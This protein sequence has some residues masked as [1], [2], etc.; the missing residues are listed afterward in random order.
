MLF[1]VDKPMAEIAFRTANTEPD[2]EIVLIQD[3]VLLDPVAHLDTDE[4]VPV[5]AVERDLSV[6]GVSSSA[7][8]EPIQYDALVEK[9]VEQEVKSFV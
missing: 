1:L 3:G 6:R 2:A 7:A 5:Y 4:E 9:I 8:V